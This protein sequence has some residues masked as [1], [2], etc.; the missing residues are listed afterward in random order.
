MARGALLADG[1]TGWHL[2][3][4]EWMLANGRVP[5]RDLFSFTQ[6]RR[7]P[8]FAWE[9][10]WDVAFAWLSRYGGLATVVLANVVLLGAVA[11]LVYRLARR[12]ERQRASWPWW[13]R[14]WPRRRLRCTGWRGPTCS[15]CCSRR[16]S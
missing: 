16:R 5:E 14:F 6:F 4:G 9:W 13:R 15:R 7:E 8:W 1:D 2:R 3:A 11:V 10:L 12:R